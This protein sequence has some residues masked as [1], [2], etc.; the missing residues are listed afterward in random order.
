MI[1]LLAWRVLLCDVIFDKYTRTR[2]ASPVWKYTFFESLAQS[3]F[4]HHAQGTVFSD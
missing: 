3:P 1:V 2:T 4:D